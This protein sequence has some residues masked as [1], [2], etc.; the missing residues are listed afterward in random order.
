MQVGAAPHW[1]PQLSRSGRFF[2]RGPRPDWWDSAPINVNKGR[3]FLACGQQI[4]ARRQ[5]PQIRSALVF[6]S[7]PFWTAYVMPAPNSES[8]ALRIY[9]NSALIFSMR[10]RVLHRL[11]AGG[12][13][14]EVYEMRLL[15]RS[16]GAIDV[17]HAAARSSF[18]WPSATILRAL[19]SGVIRRPPE[20]TLRRAMA[21]K[22]GRRMPSSCWR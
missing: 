9:R 10:M 19:S 16:K 5:Q 14:D 15:G 13:L 22:A 17:F 3:E 6:S 2:G 1:R 4:I 18:D 12:K 11:D 7:Q 8:L 21:A 20:F